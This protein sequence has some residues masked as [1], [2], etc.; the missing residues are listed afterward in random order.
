MQIDTTA[1]CQGVIN[2]EIEHGIC[3]ELADKIYTMLRTISYRGPV[4]RQVCDYDRL[5]VELS[6]IEAEWIVWSLMWKHLGEW[7]SAGITVAN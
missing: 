3:G 5:L 6:R 4:G 7:L 2:A 1:F